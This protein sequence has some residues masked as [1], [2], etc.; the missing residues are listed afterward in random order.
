[1]YIEIFVLNSNLVSIV[2]NPVFEN[3]RVLTEV[4]ELYILY[5]ICENYSGNFLRVSFNLIV[6]IFPHFWEIY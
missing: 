4:F 3:Q 2:K 5:A 6:F 1:M